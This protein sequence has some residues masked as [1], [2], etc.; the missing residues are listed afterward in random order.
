MKSD[1]L[2]QDDS[3]LNNFQKAVK[4]AVIESLRVLKILEETLNVSLQ[5]SID[6]LVERELSKVLIVSISPN[7]PMS[8]YYCADSN[9][10]NDV[11]LFSFNTY[12]FVDGYDG[13][14]KFELKVK[15]SPAIT[16]CILMQK[17]E[18]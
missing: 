13:S 8:V 4:Y 12:M 7:N 11:L 5:K 2:L 6:D 9:S 16:Q 18:V 15:H 1:F 17:L 3:V 14:V 10:E